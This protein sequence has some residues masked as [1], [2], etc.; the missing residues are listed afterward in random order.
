MEAKQGAKDCVI[1][2]T[3]FDLARGEKKKQVDFPRAFDRDVEVLCWIKDFRFVTYDGSPYSVDAWATD[4]TPKGFTA[5]ASG[6]RCA[7]RLVATWIVHYKGKPKVASGSFST[8]DMEDREDEQAENGGRVEFAK[9]TFSKPPVVLVGLSQ[10][11]HAG[12]RDLRLGVYVTA[13]DESGF[14]WQLSQYPNALPNVCQADCL[15]TLG[16]RTPK[17]P[18]VVLKQR[19][20]HLTL[21]E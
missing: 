3:K 17:M 14:D 5:H 15:Q 19:T 20:W 12:G 4:V 21:F 7:E 6:S 13:V 2:T 8:E 1:M 18:F 16:V 11:D 10:F 9:G